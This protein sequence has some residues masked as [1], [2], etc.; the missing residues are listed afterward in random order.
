MACQACSQ[1]AGGAKGATSTEAHP[2]PPTDSRNASRRL[3]CGT[4]MTSDYLVGAPSSLDR[5]QY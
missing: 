1:E 3:S 5:A 2:A 4:T